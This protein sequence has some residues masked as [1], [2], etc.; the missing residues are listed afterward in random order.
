MGITNLFGRWPKIFLILPFVPIGC[1][2]T[3]FPGSDKLERTQISLQPCAR[4][5]SVQLPPSDLPDDSHSAF[6]LRK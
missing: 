2:F 3:C 1:K 6:P 4:D 5:A